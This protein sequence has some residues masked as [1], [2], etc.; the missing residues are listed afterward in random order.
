MDD[1]N[2]LFKSIIDKKVELRILSKA[3]NDTINIIYLFISVIVYF[4]GAFI[5]FTH[6]S[7]ASPMV[8]FTIFMMFLVLLPIIL[9]EILDPFKKIGLNKSFVY[10]SKILIGEL[11]NP[12]LNNRNFV[13]RWWKEWQ[14]RF[15]FIYLKNQFFSLKDNLEDSYILPVYHSYIQ[16]FNRITKITGKQF[17][18]LVSNNQ[19]QAIITLLSSLS[20]AYFNKLGYI[21][22]D[23]P[24]SIDSFLS[25]ASSALDTIENIEIVD[26]GRSFDFQKL[27]TRK[28]L[29]ISVSLFGVGLIILSYLE[30]DFI[31]ERFNSAMGI[32][33]AILSIVSILMT[34][35]D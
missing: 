21:E 7:D 12:N 10:L 24:R 26:S 28:A 34:K 35:K 32:A 5:Y 9:G 19:Q 6:Y 18:Y 1:L 23:N 27:K 20:H 11:E 31:D 13:S 8:I 16:L 15:L 33:G 17:V 29:I 3:R 22:K 4:I 30:I 2:N 25:E 14:L